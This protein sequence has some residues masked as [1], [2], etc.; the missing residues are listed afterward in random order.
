MFENNLEA[1]GAEEQRQEE[2]SVHDLH[3][4]QDERA[5][6]LWRAR[7][8]GNDADECVHLQHVGDETWGR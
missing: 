4:G 1:S 7:A 8:K 5:L 6:S 2:G 3:V